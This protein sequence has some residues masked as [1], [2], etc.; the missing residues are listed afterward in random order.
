MQQGE[1]HILFL[2][3][4]QQGLNQLSDADRCLYNPFPRGMYM[5]MNPR[6]GMCNTSASSTTKFEVER[7]TRHPSNNSALIHYLRHG[8]RDTY[9][10]LSTLLSRLSCWF[11]RVLLLVSPFSSALFKVNELPA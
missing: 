9:F 1:Q 3:D 10:I 4:N 2:A 11:K 8:Q 7:K 6:F 5:N